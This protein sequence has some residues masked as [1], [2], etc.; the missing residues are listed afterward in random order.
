MKWKCVLNVT[1]LR[2]HIVF[3]TFGSGLC[4][5]VF[6]EYV[7]HSEKNAT[8]AAEINPPEIEDFGWTDFQRHWNSIVIATNSQMKATSLLI[9][10]DCYSPSKSFSIIFSSWIW[11]KRHDDIHVDGFW[12]YY[13]PTDRFATPFLKRTNHAILR[14]EFCKYNVLS[15]ISYNF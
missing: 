3:S 9:F 14:H 5:S 11:E 12:I 7:D 6:V 10:I 2:N 15:N 4:V 1:L 13:L 8:S